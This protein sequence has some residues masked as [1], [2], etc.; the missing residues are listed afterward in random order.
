MWTAAR[1]RELAKRAADFEG[2]LV[3][4]CDATTETVRNAIGPINCR[5][6]QGMEI[7]GIV[8]LLPTVTFPLDISLKALGMTSIATKPATEVNPLRTS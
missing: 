3:L 7:E 2:V 6:I 5:V 4:G 1:R 8:N